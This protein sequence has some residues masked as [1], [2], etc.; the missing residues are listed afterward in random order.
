MEIRKVEAR[1]PERACLLIKQFGE[2]LHD[3]LSSRIDVD[4]YAGKL[5][6]KGDVFLALDSRT[7]IGL[8]GLYT[9]DEV[10][11][12]GYI[13]LLVVHPEF[14]GRGIGS[15]LLRCAIHFSQAK[16]VTSL[17]LQTLASN[18]GARRFYERFGFEQVGTEKDKLVL[19]RRCVGSTG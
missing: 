3:P 15:D 17:R 13:S 18:I 12:C 2:Y 14:R 9:N 6:E 8:I 10:H 5:L 16:G 1:S 4:D 19:E 7:T 11:H